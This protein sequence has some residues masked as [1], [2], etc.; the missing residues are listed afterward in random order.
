M[1]ASGTE[2]LGWV[3]VVACGALAAV[4]TIGTL[5]SLLEAIMTLSNGIR[6]SS[7]ANDA[8]FFGIVS[9]VG[10]VASFWAWGLVL[11]RE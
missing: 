6:S 4:L 11:D 1:I 3:R 2:M 7:E 5:F 10:L 8:L 9:C